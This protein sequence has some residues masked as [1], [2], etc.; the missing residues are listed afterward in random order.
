MKQQY[1]KVG[2]KEVLSILQHLYD[3][4]RALSEAPPWQCPDQAQRCCDLLHAGGRSVYQI[5]AGK[6][7]CAIL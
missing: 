7:A 4:D 6:F 3:K 1:A 5:S 2:K